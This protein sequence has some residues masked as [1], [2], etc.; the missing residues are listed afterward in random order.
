MG[1]DMYAY[2]RNK[3]IRK[4]VDFKD[5]DSD[6]ELFYWRKHPNLHGWMEDLYNKK[7]GQEEFNCVN[8]KL[9]LEDIL[10]LEIDV[11]GNNLQKTEGF[12]FGS[13]SEEDKLDDLNFI[14][15]AKEAL[16]DGKSVYYTS[17]W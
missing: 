13:S 1:L 11:N 5:E 9:T 16:N 3:S 15:K 4:D 17:W 8:V 7:G 2:A 14:K 10:A 6:E 12:F